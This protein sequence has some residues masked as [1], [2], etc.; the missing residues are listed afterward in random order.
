MTSTETNRYEQQA[1]AESQQR[2]RLTRTI[3]LLKRLNEAV[4][5]GDP[6]PSLAEILAMT[7]LEHPRTDA[8]ERA[9]PALLA[10]AE[11]ERDVLNRRLRL[12]REL[13]SNARDGGVAAAPPMPTLSPAPVV[14][15]V[16]R[17]SRVSARDLDSL[18]Y[19][20][21]L[22]DD[23]G[24]IVAYNDTE[25]RMARL[26]IEAVVGRNFFTEVAPCTRVKDFEGR[27]RGLASGQGAGLVT[28][29]FTFPFPFGAQRVSVILTRHTQPGHVI[30]ALIRR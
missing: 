25:S 17:L 6:V 14:D 7:G 8:V 12:T 22:M 23:S 24:R 15:E 13:R 28:F 29:D 30:M 10:A 2:D 4:Q 5:A 19:G 26:P 21:I 16:A 27:F 20:A 1:A 3:R 9:V 18:P 11:S